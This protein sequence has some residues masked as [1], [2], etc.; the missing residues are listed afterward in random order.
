MPDFEQ[1]VT[2]S[3]REVQSVDFMYRKDLLYVG[4]P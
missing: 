1:E 2:G 4:E 3:V